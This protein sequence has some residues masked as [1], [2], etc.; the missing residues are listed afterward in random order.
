MVI[1]L[2]QNFAKYRQFNIKY[3]QFN[4]K[5]VTTMYLAIVSIDLYDTGELGWTTSYTVYHA[6]LCHVNINMTFKTGLHSSIFLCLYVIY[7][8][9]LKMGVTDLSFYRIQL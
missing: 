5:E 2:I 8:Q 3:R 9:L 4:N 6:I 1:Y 7:T